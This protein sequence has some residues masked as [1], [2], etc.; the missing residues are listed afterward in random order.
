[1]IRF[2]STNRAILE[3]SAIEMKHYQESP[4]RA[5]RAGQSTNKRYQTT[6]WY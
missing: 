4:W 5:I 3:L 2:L 6:S 1:M